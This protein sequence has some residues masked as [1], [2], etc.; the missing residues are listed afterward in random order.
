[1]SQITSPI[2]TTTPPAARRSSWLLRA[3][4]GLLFAAL[5]ASALTVVALVGYTLLGVGD[6]PTA[7]RPDLAEPITRVEP[8]SATPSEAPIISEVNVWDKHGPINV[9]LLGLDA[10]DCMAPE[11][12]T[13]RADT[14][15]LVRIDPESDAVS[16]LSI[17]RDLYVYIDA[18]ESGGPVGARKINTAHVFGTRFDEDGR[19]VPHSGPNLVKD[20]I[21]SNL[22]LTAHRYVRIDFQ[23]FEQIVDALGGVEVDVPSS[24]ED[25]SIGLY[26]SEYPDGQC[27]TMTIDF[28][29]GRQTLDGAQALQYARSRKS[30]S[31]FDRS[32][33]QMQVLMAIRDRGTRLGVI[34]DLP[35]LIPA[36]RETI[37]TDLSPDEILSLAGIA[38]R[39]DDEKVVRLQL[40][41]N[42]LYDDLLVIDGVPQWVLRLQQ[43]PFEAIRSQFMD[44]ELALMMQAQ[45]TAAEQAE[46]EPFGTE[47]VQP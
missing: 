22:G 32:R 24:P 11:G 12:L 28:P 16:M 2:P 41:E 34:L 43:E 39:I 36:L 5:G 46:G 31:D 8:I 4:F 23:G 17:P 13:R 33:R 35:K 15:I 25:P 38:R 30:T 37:D 9:L 29:P 10:D 19:E 47:P 7:A 3:L 18:S 44:P 20:T 42:A 6:R 21:R 14:I 27:G 26:D 40:D 1:M 45:D